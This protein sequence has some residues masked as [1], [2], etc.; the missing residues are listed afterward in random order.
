MFSCRL[1][2]H[3]FSNCVCME[4]W[5]FPIASILHWSDLEL[6]HFEQWSKVLSPRKNIIWFKGQIISSLIC[7]SPCSTGMN[8]Y[9]P[10]I[11]LMYFCTCV[12]KYL[13]SYEVVY[14]VFVYW[15]HLIPIEDLPLYCPSVWIVRQLFLRRVSSRQ[16]IVIGEQ[17]QHHLCSAPPH[18]VY[19]CICVFNVLTYIC[20]LVCLCFSICEFVPLDANTRDN[21]S[22]LPLPSLC[23]HNGL[24]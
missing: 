20:V 2:S 17:R 22:R 23:P 10:Q 19:F 4:D 9:Q 5:T 7:L 11:V 14:F 13:C 12:V 18:Y 8:Q 1:C 3:Q 15:Y 24:T 16:F 6:H 21:I